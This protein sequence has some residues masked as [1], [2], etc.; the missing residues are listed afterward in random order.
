MAYFSSDPLVY[1]ILT[2]IPAVFLLYDSPRWSGGFLVLIFGVSV[3]NGGGFYIE[4]FG[5]KSVFSFLACLSCGSTILSIRFERELEAMRKELAEATSRSGRSSP[6]S[7][8][9][10]PG[11]DDES[12]PLG[13]AATLPTEPGNKQ[14]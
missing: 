2:E 7:G 8:L 10:L 3:W 4:V 9:S 13:Q 14:D 6:N 1:G 5:R 11:S 12:S